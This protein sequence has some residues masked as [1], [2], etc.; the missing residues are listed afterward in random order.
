M[1]RASVSIRH[2]SGQVLTGWPVS[3]EMALVSREQV[4]GKLWHGRVKLGLSEE[5]AAPDPYEF[6]AR[7][8]AH[9]CPYG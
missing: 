7:P 8:P 4:M 1:A 5:K 6:K 9:S 3:S 2:S